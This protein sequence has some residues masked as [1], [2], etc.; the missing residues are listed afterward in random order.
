[1]HQ[2]TSVICKGPDPPIP[3]GSLFRLSFSYGEAQLFDFATIPQREAYKML[4]IIK[5]EVIDEADNTYFPEPKNCENEPFP[6]PLDDL[7]KND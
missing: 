6:E 2:V 7:L 1:M 4:K 3:F 5:K